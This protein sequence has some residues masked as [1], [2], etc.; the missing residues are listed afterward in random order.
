MSKKILIWF[1]VLTMGL[2]SAAWIGGGVSEAKSSADFSDLK[3]LDAATKAKLDAMFSAGIFEGV[4]DSSFGLDDNMNRAQFAKVAALIFDLKIDEDLK[5][6]SF[7]D[8]KADD[9]ATGYALPYIEAV[10]AAGITDGVGDGAFNPAGEVTKEQ[11]ATFLVRGLGQ[12]ARAQSAPG[13]GD[14]TVSDWAQ[15]YVQLA[16][17]QKLLGNSPSGTFGGT[18]QASR[19]LLATGSFESA[20]EFETAKPLEVSGANFVAGNKLELMLTVAISQNSIDLSK[21]MIN[22]VP[23]DPKLD[24]FVLSED[25]KTIIIKL[26]EGFKLDTSKTPVIV[27]DGLKTLFDNEVNNEKSKPIPIKVTV[28][29]VIP[30]AVTYTPSPTPSTPPSTPTPTPVPDVTLTI[31]DVN[32][33]ITQTTASYRVT[34]SVTGT[35]YYS[36]LPT[37]SLAPSLDGIK[38]GTNAIVYGSVELQGTNGNL[39]LS[40]L[41][42]NTSYVLYAYELAND[43][44][45]KISS[46]RFQT[47]PGEQEIPTVT[48]NISGTSRIMGINSVVEGFTFNR[49]DLNIDTYY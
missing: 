26:R 4:S 38:L 12:E 6:S 49:T 48:F 10:M 36:V 40:E 13:V 33:V 23:L 35:V 15:G 27:V 8:V 18:A 41:A 5:K 21:I 46:V 39:Y 3:D 29:P 19:G 45:S 14:N 32:G 43:K 9:A 25:K 7:I 47:L 22:S 34:G 31:D 11:L 2:T 17:E 24:S 42:A 16:L 30:P 44:T 1:T 20:K 28:P 37:D